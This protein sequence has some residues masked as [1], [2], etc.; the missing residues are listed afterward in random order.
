MDGKVTCYN[1]INML[2]TLEQPLLT[3][4]DLKSMRKF[5]DDKV[6]SE[7]KDIF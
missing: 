1:A 7:L 5:T 4:D 3:L 6:L 2:K